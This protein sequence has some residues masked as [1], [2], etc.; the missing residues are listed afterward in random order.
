MLALKIQKRYIKY[1]L[2]EKKTPHSVQEF[3]SNIGLDEKEFYEY[4][5]M[6]KYELNAFL[7]NFFDRSN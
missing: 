7:V 1:L 3:I 4:F 5:E 2:E 6:K